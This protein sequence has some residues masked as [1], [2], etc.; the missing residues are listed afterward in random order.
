MT[1]SRV[2]G[3]RPVRPASGN[4]SSSS[5]GEDTIEHDVGSA[6]GGLASPVIVNGAQVPRGFAGPDDSHFRQRQ[7]V[8]IAFTLRWSITRPASASAMP[9]RICSR[10]HC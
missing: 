6:D 4:R 5:T 10:C 3:I 2:P 1:S 9:A 7:R 8:A